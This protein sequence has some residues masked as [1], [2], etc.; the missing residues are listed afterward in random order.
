MIRQKPQA[1]TSPPVR[2]REVK[3]PPLVRLQWRKMLRL[4]VVYPD[5]LVLDAQCM[6]G[7][8]LHQLMRRKP[9]AR[10][11]G[12]CFTPP[13]LRYAR[14]LV[15]QGDIMFADERDFP[16]ISESMDVAYIARG[17]HALE[18]P[19]AT[20]REM[21]RLLRKG[22]QTLIAGV[23]LPQPFRVLYNAA[24]FDERP[25]S[26]IRPRKEMTDLLR[27]AGFEQIYV[28]RAG[29]ISCVATGVKK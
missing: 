18:N 27:A 2:A 15:E 4:M 1:K 3:V 28:V 24:V 6:E 10:L 11:C 13:Q 22:G 25:Q 14:Q 26:R 21:H 7:T 5:D 17:L 19:L 8:L 23:C 12:A 16:W 29:L 20:L 9:K